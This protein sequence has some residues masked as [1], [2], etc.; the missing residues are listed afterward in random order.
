MQSKK[1]T[2]KSITKDKDKKLSYEVTSHIDKAVSKS[3]ERLKN[4]AVLKEGFEDAVKSLMTQTSVSVGE[5]FERSDDC[6]GKLK[7]ISR[8]ILKHGLRLVK[9]EEAL[10][11]T[12]K[13]VR[14]ISKSI[15]S[16][17]LKVMDTTVG[18]HGIKTIG[19]ECEKIIANHVN[20]TNIN[21][22]TVNSSHISSERVVSRNAEL[23]KIDA[24]IID[25]EL[26][27]STGVKS[28]LLESSRADIG[29]VKANIV[30][31]GLI[32]SDEINAMRDMIVK[33][34]GE[35]A[36]LKSEIT[37][38]KASIK[39]LSESSDSKYMEKNIKSLRLD[40][41]RTRSL[42]A[43]DADIKTM[44]A[45]VQSFKTSS[46][47]ASKSL[48]REGY[49]GAIN[50]V[51]ASIHDREV[52][53]SEGVRSVSVRH[54]AELAD[55]VSIKLPF[56][57]ISANVVV[58]DTRDRYSIINNCVIQCT[59]DSVFVRIPDAKSKYHIT[60]TGA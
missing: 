24:H 33:Q 2:D 38:I 49:I 50:G 29:K 23:G 7:A 44:S 17:F 47:M 25:S 10:S 9:I 3:L 55:G 27:A 58:K 5:L 18:L 16:R 37:Q 43:E 21:S 28:K 51:L 20:T 41:I 34:A 48:R 46:D 35:I 57:G 26:I 14:I 1:S 4:V 60:V 6:Y 36:S 40:S 12:V 31:A 53:M 56:S 54:G 52:V 19:V 11:G 13:P 30:E 59:E 22:D 39:A 42:V 8:N 15:A 45:A 32:V